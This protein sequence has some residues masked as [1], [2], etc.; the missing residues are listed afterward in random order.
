MTVPWGGAG[1]R[2][3]YCGLTFPL[4]IGGYDGRFARAI[5]VDQGVGEY[6]AV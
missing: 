1:S 6:Y 4:N 3:D 2:H 5:R